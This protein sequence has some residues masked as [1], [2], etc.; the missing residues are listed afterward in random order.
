MSH[1][2]NL[3]KNDTNFGGWRP[4]SSSNNPQ[5]KK[6]YYQ[7]KI[8]PLSNKNNHWLRHLNIVGENDGTF[9]HSGP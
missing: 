3:K 7:K 1:I 8:P 2:C 9:L 5:T 6:S 4:V